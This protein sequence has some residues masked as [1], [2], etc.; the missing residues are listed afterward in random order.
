MQQLLEGVCRRG[1][2]RGSFGG[3]GGC[4]ELE[5]EEGSRGVE[6]GVFVVVR[7]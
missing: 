5:R 1:Y 3:D 7:G 2:P 6:V 4:G